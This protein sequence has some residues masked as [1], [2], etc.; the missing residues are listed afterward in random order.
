[1]GKALKSQ[2]V[3]GLLAAVFITGS[4]IAGLMPVPA[5]TKTQ[6]AGIANSHL[7]SLGTVDS[8]VYKY[9]SGQ[10]ANQYLYTYKLTST[11]VGISFF[12]VGINDTLNLTLNVAN[13]NYANDGGVNPLSWNAIGNNPLQSVDAGF[14]VTP[15]YSGQA[16]ALLWFVCDYAPV[17]G[18][19]SVFGTSSGVPTFAAGQLYTIPE[20]TTIIMLTTGALW[21]C[22][23][24]KK[25]VA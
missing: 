24:R 16:S 4:A 11:S 22:T 5:G 12:S 15:I 14:F 19:G 21:I 13:I 20:P 6:V 7:G 18:L 10:Y 8:Y 9:T 3:I 2:L 25:S 17:V 23:R 1:M